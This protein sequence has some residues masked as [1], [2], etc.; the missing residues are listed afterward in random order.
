MSLSVR[1]DEPQLSGVWG[2][3]AAAQQLGFLGKQ[4]TSTSPVLEGTN[5]TPGVK[6]KGSLHT[7]SL[8]HFYC[9]N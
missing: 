4:T 1:G 8:F 5:A 7:P 3:A 2:Q 6:D 9:Y